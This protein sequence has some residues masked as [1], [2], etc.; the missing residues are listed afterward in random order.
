MGDKLN[1]LIAFT[2]LGCISYYMY[3]SSRQKDPL[4]KYKPIGI[5]QVQAFER[6][7]KYIAIQNKNSGIENSFG[8]NEGNNQSEYNSNRF[9][10][11]YIDD[12]SPNKIQQKP[13]NQNE[14]DLYSDDSIYGFRLSDSKNGKNM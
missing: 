2:G 12:N 8:N 4:K 6:D 10:Q 9:S 13:K 1:L 5:D 3:Y 7:N 11:N 14:T